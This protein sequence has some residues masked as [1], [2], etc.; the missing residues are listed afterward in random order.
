MIEFQ[1]PVLENPTGNTHGTFGEQSP[2]NILARCICNNRGILCVCLVFGR[3]RNYKCIAALLATLWSLLLLL[4]VNL[5]ML[6]RSVSS[7]AV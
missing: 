4:L 7:S 2:N 5:M 1:A 3:I 6:L